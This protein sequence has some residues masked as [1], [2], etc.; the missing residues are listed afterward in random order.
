MSAGRVESQ[1]GA[2]PELTGIISNIAQPDC[3]PGRSRAQGTTF[4]RLGQIRPIWP[5]RVDRMDFRSAEPFGG[6]DRVDVGFW[7]SAGRPD[8]V[9]TRVGHRLG[10]LAQG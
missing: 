5:D 10:R 2:W 1:S 8:R 7:A 3:L 4:N 9:H 6:P